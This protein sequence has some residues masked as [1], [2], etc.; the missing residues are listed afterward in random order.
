MAYTVVMH[1]DG[2]LI[3]AYD[4]SILLGLESV[5]KVMIVPILIT[6]SPYS[7]KFG[8]NMDNSIPF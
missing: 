8:I 1:S 6:D 5:T 3:T 2:V 7:V 4:A